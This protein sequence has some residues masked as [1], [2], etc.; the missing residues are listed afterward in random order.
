MS[1]KTLKVK[2]NKIPSGGWWLS[3]TGEIFMNH[4]KKL[5]DKG[6]SEDEAVEIL[7]DLY[8]AVASEFGG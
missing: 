2:I 5:T 6:F 4:A 8:Y 7:E 3:N 1:K